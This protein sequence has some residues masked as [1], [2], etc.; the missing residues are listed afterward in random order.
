VEWRRAGLVLGVW[1]V[2]C[3]TPAPRTAEDLRAEIAKYEHADAAASEER[4]AALFAKLD[5][6]IAALRADELA[7]AP[8][9]RAEST[10]RR[11]ALTAERREL[12]SAYLQ[13]RVARL[14]VAAE[15]AFRGMA[16]QLG[17]G[18]EDMGRTLRESTREQGAPQ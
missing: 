11:E 12:Q 1:L 7:K 14:G 2:A 3:G 6:E 18:L 16:E 4:I 5:A 17:R 9:E 8:E 15:E 13:A 10:R